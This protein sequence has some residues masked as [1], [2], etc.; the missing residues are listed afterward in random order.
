MGAE[1]VTSAPEPAPAAS[2]DEL[3]K[4]NADTIEH[5]DPH[6]HRHHHRLDAAAELLRKT[7]EATDGARIVVSPADDKRILR[8]IDLVILPLILIVYFLQVS[9]TPVIF[10]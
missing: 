6:A 10:L 5:A 4:A 9:Y 7:Q 1:D 8:K 3:P 2:H